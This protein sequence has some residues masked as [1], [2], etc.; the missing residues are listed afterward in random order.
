MILV[1]PG[2]H[3]IVEKNGG[4]YTTYSSSTTIIVK[5]A[6]TDLKLIIGIV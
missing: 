2:F 1:K 6:I 3:M 5:A 4:D